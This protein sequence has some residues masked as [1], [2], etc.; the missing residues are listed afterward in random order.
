S[1]KRQAREQAID[2][3]LFLLS[4]VKNAR[5]S[6]RWRIEAARSVLPYLHPRLASTEV[7]IPTPIEHVTRYLSKEDLARKL[8]ERGLPPFVFGVDAPTLESEP[9]GNGKRS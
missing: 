4:V 1:L 3:K 9:N 2:P 7:R 5:H 8:E 6:L